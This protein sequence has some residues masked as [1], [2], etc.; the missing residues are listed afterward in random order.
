M[1]L[2][3]NKSEQPAG[4]MVGLTLTWDVFKFFNHLHFL[5]VDMINFNM[6]CI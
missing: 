1:Y 2:N 4:N 3:E 5:S 6:R